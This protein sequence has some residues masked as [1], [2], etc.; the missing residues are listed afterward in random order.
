MRIKHTL[1]LLL[2]AG[3]MTS[4]AQNHPLN[5]NP[6]KFLG[7]ITTMGQIRSDYDQYWDQLT[8]ENETKWESIERQPGVFD[9]ST[10]RREFDYCK[11]HGFK[12][13]FHALLWGAQIPSYLQQLNAE[14][15]LKAIT[16]W[17]DA[18]AKEFPDLEYIDVANE[19]VKGGNG[20]PH[21]PYQ[22]TRI[23][24]ALGGPGKTGYDWLAT[25]FM[26]A[27]ERWPKAVLIYNDY[28][29][30]QW[31]TDEYI[32]LINAI[33]AAG[34]PI[35][36]A[37]CQSHDLNDMEKAE[38]FKAALEK[39][40]DGVQLPIFIS[41]YD[42]NKANDS[43]QLE[44]YKAQFPIMWEADY[45][46][47]VTL[48]GYI[49]GQT[50]VDD[51]D[52]KGASGLIRDGQERPA[53]KWLREYMMTDAA[54]NAKSPLIDVASDYAFI[55]PS[56]NVVLIGD[57]ATIKAKASSSE[58]IAEVRVYKG[59]DGDTVLFA[60]ADTS[61]IDLTWTPVEKGDF[62]F[63][64]QV[65]SSVSS[66]LFERSCT[67]KACEPAKPFHGTPI[68]LPGKFEAED[69]DLGENTIAYSDSDP[70][71]NHGYSENGT[72][73]RDI[74]GIDIDK[75]DGDGF[76]VGWTN[77]GE[78]MQYTVKVEVE[79]LMM[80]TA[81]VSSGTNGS[82]FSIRMGDTNLTGRINVPQTASNSW[83]TYTEIKGRTL[84]PMPAGTY[85]IRIQIEGSSC[86]I[87]YIVF[88]TAT[89]SEVL[90]EAYNGKPAA[91]PGA[92]EVE[93]YDVA[94]KG[95]VAQ[96]YSDNDSD[97]QG[98]ASFRTSEGVD[99][100]IGNAGKAIG[101]TAQGEWLI[102][103]VKVEKTQKYYW[104]AV[105][106][107]GANGAAF[108]L[109]LD[110]NDITGKISIPQTAN[111]NWNTYKVVKGET[112]IELPEGTHILK[113]VIEGP[114]GNIDKVVFTTEPI[115]GDGGLIGATDNKPTTID[116]AEADSGLFD[117]Y[118]IMGVYRGTVEIQNNNTSVLNGLF[119]RG[120]YILRNKATGTAKRV[121]VN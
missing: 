13:K 31:D 91:I 66:T 35:D 63:K 67:I 24:E 106:S 61:A 109:Y 26:M 77:S 20:N 48:W 55:S 32:K 58:E 51:G 83:G 120:I 85:P 9:F 59:F 43:I 93:E 50:W 98:D 111:N 52:I 84:V 89:G 21:S 99:V 41:E 7:N 19:A 107:S 119:E 54:I 44:R 108:R 105:V 116:D 39:V 60:K 45:V 68:A 18:V 38:D 113:L 87:D 86:N 65:L 100:V 114:N 121:M 56:A 10:A 46:A 76:V 36:A 103:T 73:Y 102:Y 75:N 47:G 97:N 25:A 64:L 96:T 74:A 22:M 78:W 4:Q 117:V 33:K 27:R 42:I 101:Y 82:A 8:P 34:G 72:T 40:H 28:N 88:E 90:T 94:R 80:W 115:D 5:Y 95:Y 112:S 79:Q 53:L 16:R 23:I 37:G 11:E 3:A 69:F 71:N 110:D 6:N 14:E 2:A 17:F 57:E 15:T 29:T 12:F 49:F 104:N 30:F 62:T 70:D 81:R 92:I 1:L 118:T